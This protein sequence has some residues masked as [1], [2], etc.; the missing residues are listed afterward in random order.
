MTDKELLASDLFELNDHLIE[1]EQVLAEIRDF[2]DAPHRE[3]L[4]QLLQS[5]R[6]M[7]YVLD[8]EKFAATI[9]SSIKIISYLHVR[10]LKVPEDLMEMLI[11]INDLSFKIMINNEYDESNI[12]SMVSKVLTDIENRAKDNKNNS[13]LEM[14]SEEDSVTLFGD[15][16]DP[17]ALFDDEDEN[18]EAE[19]TI[20]SPVNRE[21]PPENKRLKILIADDVFENRLLL[22]AILTPYGH[23]ELATDGQEAVDAWKIAAVDGDPYDVVFLDILM[24]ELDGIGAL[25]N[26]RAMERKDGLLDGKETLIFMVS[27]VTS[28]KEVCQAFFKGY[29]TDYIGK[30]VT[31]KM[32][33]DKVKEY[34]LI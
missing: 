10:N 21:D 28:P 34:G 18:D 5:V 3:T 32:V 7:A 9:E 20:P 8:F 23:C 30:P 19:E 15:D 13:Q 11:Y 2:N 16:E 12:R 29:C 31:K 14:K 26:I 27:A 1:V 4:I 24:P 17:V 22:K 25:K 33:L 6:D